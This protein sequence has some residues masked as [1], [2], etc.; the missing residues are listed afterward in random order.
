M[1]MDQD[2]PMSR[3]QGKVLVVGLVVMVVI[4]FA[5]FGGFLPGLK[6]NYTPPSTVLVEG[7][8]Y[9]YTT[10]WLNS[11]SVFSNSTA[12]QPFVFHNVTFELWVTN[13]DSPTGGLVHGNGT[14]R[15]GSVASF[16]LGNSVSPPMSTSLFVSSDRGFAVYW[17]GGFLAG[18]S[19]RLMVHA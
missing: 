9:Y 6:P 8:P 13:W 11:P 7:E 14:E 5:L 2:F 12:P 10:V 18:P 16:V 17:S 15:N 4:G 19:V 3:T 1:G